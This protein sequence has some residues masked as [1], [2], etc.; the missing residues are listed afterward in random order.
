MSGCHIA[1]V[2]RCDSRADFDACPCYGYSVVGESF[3]VC[4]YSGYSAAAGS[5]STPVPA[6]H[7]YRGTA[8][9]LTV[10]FV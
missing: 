4:P 6:A 3:D 10:S 8:D 7:S 5:L 9:Y 1:T 2:T